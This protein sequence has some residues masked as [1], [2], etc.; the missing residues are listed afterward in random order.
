MSV[1][2]QDNSFRDGNNYDYYVL[3]HLK[4]IKTKEEYSVNL[5]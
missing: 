4:I 1:S 3:S 2:K 5:P